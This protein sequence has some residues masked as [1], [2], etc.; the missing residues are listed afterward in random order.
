[1]LWI[2]GGLRRDFVVAVQR[3][4]AEGHRPGTERSPL[5]RAARLGKHDPDLQAHA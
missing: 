4:K 5:A 1:L 3:V 2:T